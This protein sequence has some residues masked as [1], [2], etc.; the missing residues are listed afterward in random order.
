MIELDVVE[1][2]PAMMISRFAFLRSSKLLMLDGR[3]IHST[4]LLEAELPIQVNLRRSYLVSAALMIGAST[5]PERPGMP[6]VRPSG[7]ATLKR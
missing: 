3:R 1:P 4:K 5:K 2:L 7:L 6:S